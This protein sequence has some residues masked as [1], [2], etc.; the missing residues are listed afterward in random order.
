M[1]LSCAKNEKF[2]YG[3]AAFQ[4]ITNIAINS[5]YTSIYILWLSYHIRHLFYCSVM[6]ALYWEWLVMVECS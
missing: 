5:R 3:V 4:G 1:E 6:K 2:G